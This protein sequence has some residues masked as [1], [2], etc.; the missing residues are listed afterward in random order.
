MS[1]KKARQKEERIKEESK[2]VAIET[3]EADISEHSWF[4]ASLIIVVFGAILRCYDLAL[5]PFHHDEGVNGHFMIRLVRE[6]IYK[7]DPE[8]YHGPTIYYFSLVAAKLFGLNTVAM[9]LVPAL[10]GIA[11]IWLLLCLRRY[12]G[13]IGALVAA[14]LIAVSPGAIYLSR[15]FIHETLFIFFTLG[16]IVAALYYYETAKLV[17]S[18]LGSIS[19]ALLFATKETAFISIGVILLAWACVVVYLKL[20]NNGLPWETKEQ[21]KAR[22]RELDQ[23]TK[24]VFFEKLGDQNNLITHLLIAVSVFLLVYVLFYSSFFTNNKGVWDSLQ[25]FQIWAKTSSKDHTQSGPFAYFSWLK[26]EELP[27]MVLCATGFLIALW[28]ARNR[29]AI[30]AGAWAIGIT[31]AYSI[32]KYKTP[33]LALNFL[34]PMA[35]VGGYCVDQL[36]LLS[37]QIEKRVF[38]GLVLLIA[39]GVGIYQAISINFYH[40][41][42]DKYPYIYAHT[43]RQFLD[44][45]REFEKYAKRAQGT[46]EELSVS[47]VSP[48]YWPL[49]WYTRDY[50]GVGYHG[51]MTTISNQHIVIAKDEQRYQ[52]DELIGSRY[53][54]IG[55]YPL[56][57]GVNLLLYVRSDLMQ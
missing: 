25:A 56:R 47:V 5:K 6:G 3:R 42:D 18:V 52:L 55:E 41:D 11:T 40:Y 23:A 57:P 28:R 17:Y 1:K 51:G 21:A 26:D 35:I 10:F 53:T 31:A 27:L 44:M 15:Y 39:L 29:F 32:I 34:V 14:A 9:R 19:A 48:D 24:K 38:S 13:S 2:A 8:N 43:P 37:K 30:F 46:K 33:W 22:K 16:I 45:V 12:I 54:L 50:K 49:P 7:Y 36:G 20:V 4:I